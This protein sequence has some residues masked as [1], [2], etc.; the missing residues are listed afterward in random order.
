MKIF[1]LIII[2]SLLTS[3]GNKRELGHEVLSEKTDRS[4]IC[5]SN[6]DFSCVVGKAIDLEVGPD[7]RVTNKISVDILNGEIRLAVSKAIESITTR[8]F[9]GTDYKARVDGVYEIYRSSTDHEIIAYGVLGYGYG[10][11]DYQD[12]ILIGLDLTGRL[13]LTIE[14]NY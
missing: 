9:P 5:E 8:H 7:I 2:A 1:T 6:S 4:R 14:D 12:V 10:E 13:T 11:P 3:C